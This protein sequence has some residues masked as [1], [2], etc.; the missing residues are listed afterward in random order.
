M[1]LTRQG[2][3]KIQNLWHA[4]ILQPPFW[5]QVTQI[6]FDFE[7]VAQQVAHPRQRTYEKSNCVQCSGSSGGTKFKALLAQVIYVNQ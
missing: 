4:K 1:F 5:T 3:Y 2:R 7:V 6:H